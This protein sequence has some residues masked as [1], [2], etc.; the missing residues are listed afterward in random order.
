MARLRA[1][2]T[3]IGPL[4]DLFSGLNLLSLLSYLY[5]MTGEY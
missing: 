5:I 3:Y 4:N 1:T 2:T